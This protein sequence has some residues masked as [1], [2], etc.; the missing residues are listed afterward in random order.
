M[1]GPPNFVEP[2]STRVVH[3]WGSLPGSGAPI[4]PESGVLGK[5]GLPGCRAPVISRSYLLVLFSERPVENQFS[6]KQHFKK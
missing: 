4:L 2:G 1:F 6:L 5:I 3:G